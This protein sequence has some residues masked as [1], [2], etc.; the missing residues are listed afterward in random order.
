MKNKPVVWID[1]REKENSHVT[2]Y[3]DSKPIDH[4]T[5]KLP[6][7]D[8]MS[9]DNAR[10]II[11]RKCGILEMVST[12]GKD[13]ERFKKELKEATRYGIH[14]IILIEEE[15]YFCIEDIKSWC[16]PYRKKNPRSM[17]GETA[18]KIL[19]TYTQYYNVEIQF[20]CK[21]DAGQRILELLNIH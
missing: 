12:L 7:G 14:L 3:F 4:F 19:N 15:G 21:G 20:T 1:S 18:Y 17:S 10:V 11:E 8:Y 9:L 5:S 13:H 16:N 2:E 6:Y